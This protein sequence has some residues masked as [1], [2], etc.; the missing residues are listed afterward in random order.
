MHDELVYEVPAGTVQQSAM[1]VKDIMEN[2]TERFNMSV[3]MKV[4]VKAGPTW[5]SLQNAF[6]YNDQ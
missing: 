5:A 6:D 1:T 4:N 2:M 3:D